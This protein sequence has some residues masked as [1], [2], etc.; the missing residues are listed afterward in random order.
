LRAEWWKALTQIMEELPNATLVALTATPPYDVTGSEWDKYEELCGPVDEE[1]SVPELVKAGTLCPHQDHV[2]LVQPPPADRDAVRDYDRTVGETCRTLE[3]D[4]LLQRSVE[5]H[6]WLQARDEA[7]PAILD[8]PETAFALL[9]FLRHKALPMPHRL[10]QA[11]DVQPENLPKMDRRWWQV[12]LRAYLKDEAWPHD[13]ECRKRRDEIAR[14]LRDRGL[15]WRQELR[16]Q[17]SGPMLNRLSLSP[18]KIQACVEIHHTEHR[19]RSE[20]LRQVILTDF[21]GDRPAPDS[22]SPARLSAWPVFRALV[23]SAP[24]DTAPTMGLLTGRLAAVHKNLIPALRE[25]APFDLHPSEIQDLP[26]FVRIEDSPGRL[27]PAFTALLAQGKIRALVGTRSLLGE[28]W[29]APAINSLILA[30]FVGSFMLTNQMRGRAIRVDRAHPDKASSVWHIAAVDPDTVTGLGDLEELQRRFTTFVGLDAEEPAIESGVRRLRLPFFAGD[31]IDE[32]AVQPDANNAAMQRRLADI[33][34]LAS[35]W[36]MA[37]DLGTEGRVLPGVR[38]EHPPAMGPFHFRNTLRRALLEAFWLMTAVFS[39][40]VRDPRTDNL[41][42]LLGLVMIG[43]TI[44]FLVALPKFIRTLI[45]WLRHL[46]VDG[47]LR[48]IA[49]AVRDGLCAADLIETNRRQLGIL[50]TPLSDGSWSAALTGASYYEQCLFANALGEVLGPIGNPRYLLTRHEGM[51]FWKQMDYHAV[52]SLLA[53]NK[54]RAEQLH[55]IWQKRVC[56]SQLIY[57][58]TPEARPILLRAR[59]R[60]FSSAFQHRAERLDRWQ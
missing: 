55:A 33:S 8:N 10:L 37:V 32:R 5:Q 43:A 31:R 46:P 24:P 57:T 49:L 23:D 39:S 21:I 47:S 35:H 29:D 34:N 53:V 12:F 50:T 15:I 36:K 44:A 9:I 22:S 4:P 41:R 48:Q 13:P 3:Q 28:G 52:P 27:L 42:D 16:I 2:W 25:A 51:A 17:E 56:P 45:L 1:I 18:A 7:L 14:M 11:L 38:M 58:R 30:S 40:I 60:A 20:A 59:A 6:P 26:G 19:L 54:E